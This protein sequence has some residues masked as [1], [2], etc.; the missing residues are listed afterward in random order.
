MLIY[1][2]CTFLIKLRTSVITFVLLD[3]A[4]LLL[5]AVS[6]STAEIKWKS[7]SVFDDGHQVCDCEHIQNVADQTRNTLSAKE[8]KTAV[9]YRRVL[10]FLFKKEMFIK[11]PSSSSD[12][13]VRNIALKVSEKQ[14]KLLGNP[15]SIESMDVLVLDDLLSQIVVQSKEDKL[16]YPLRTLLLD[17]YRKELL[18]SLPKWNSPVVLIP[19]AS[20]ILFFFVRKI[21]FSKLRFSAIF[22]CLLMFACVV[23]YGMSYMDCIY[24]LEVEQ[25]IKLSGG[26]SN[27]NPC[28]DYH[29]ESESRLGFVSSMIFGSSENKCHEY[30]KKTLK[31]SKRYCDPLDVGI[32]WLAQVQMSYLGEVVKKFT[33]LISH[34]TCKEEPS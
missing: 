29:R 28:K 9:Y 6:R 17:L 33:D 5:I 27:N 7:P 14:L 16:D 19:F 8:L 15:L 22:I 34:F 4:F 2:L 13:Y 23:S 26:D 31:P 20:I 12:Y 25:M 18:D 11:D 30:M 21:H 32:K 3:T 10:K 24:E 1:K